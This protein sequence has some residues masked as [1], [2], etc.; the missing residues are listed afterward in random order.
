MA[1][2]RFGDTGPVFGLTEETTGFAQDFTVLEDYEEAMV[3][4]HVGETKA[5]GMFNKKW[6]G[7][8]TLVDK[9]GATLPSTATAVALAN[10]TATTAKCVITSKE[11][12][13]EQTGFQ[14]NKYTF[15]AWNSITL[16]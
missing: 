6:S 13:P 15:K 1:V 14:S 5:Y 4:D 8:F 10:L 16:T 12:T 3:P 2:T 9:N 11:R 7:S